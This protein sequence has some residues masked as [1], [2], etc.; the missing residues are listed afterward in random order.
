MKLP[1]PAEIWAHEDEKVREFG[2]A[3]FAFLCIVA[4]V[5]GR[6]KLQACGMSLFPVA[7]SWPILW[8]AMGPWLLGAWAVLTFTSAFPWFSRPVYVAATI[9]SMII[10]FVMGHVVLL[11]LFV[12]L[13]VTIGRLRAASSPIRKSFEKD[14]Q[15]YW[16][17]HRPAPEAGRYYRQY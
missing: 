11:L 1:S 9:F 16:I 7:N 3:F 6:R 4:L 13:F 14:A 10:G 2:K 17:K 12:T 15:S 8:G 5:V